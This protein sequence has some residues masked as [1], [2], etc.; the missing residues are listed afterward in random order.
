MI[1]FVREMDFEYGRADQVS[2]LLRRVVACNP[3]PFTYLGTGT[4]I[5]GHGQVAVV[6]PG[7]ALDDHLDA[8]LDAVRGERVTHILTTHTHADHSPLSQA[9]QARTGASIYGR[10]NPVGPSGEHGDLDFRPDILVKDGQEIAGPGWTL[11]TLA[12]PG[13]ASNHMAYALLEEHALLVGDHIMGWSTTVVSPPDGD[14]SAYY[15]SLDRVQARHFNVLWPTHGPPVHDVSAFID[16]YRAH[17]LNREAQIVAQLA[18]GP[19]RIADLVPVLYASVDPSL[20]PAAARSVLAH[21]IHLVRTGHVD[22]T[23]PLGPDADFSLAGS[24]HAS[25]HR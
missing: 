3:G 17:R 8:I 24:G 2:P 20:H 19:S 14:M 18:A 22:V 10:P 15:K 12:T 4:Y 9:L 16:A 25:E 1:P 7:P 5:V 11:R 23:E 13:H 21:L 6:D